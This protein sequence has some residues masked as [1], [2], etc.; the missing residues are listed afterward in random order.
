[1]IPVTF[2][3]PPP[4]FEFAERTTKCSAEQTTVGK[5]LLINT[6]TYIMHQANLGLH[7]ASPNDR[8]KVFGTLP[9]QVQATI[10]HA[11]IYPIFQH[12]NFSHERRQVPRGASIA[13]SPPTLSLAFSP[14][15]VRANSLERV[16]CFQLTT[17]QL[18]YHTRPLKQLL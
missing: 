13:L 4:P 16:S 12:V 3:L 10:V 9:L 14:A 7:S 18:N 2:M 1:M 11:F 17:L 6:C 8:N 15:R 5:T